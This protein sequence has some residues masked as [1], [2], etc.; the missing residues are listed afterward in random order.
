MINTLGFLF[1]CR[2][3]I[4]LCLLHNSQFIIARIR[5]LREGNVF[6]HVCQSFYSQGE[7]PCDHHPMMI[8]T[9]RIG[10]PLSH[11]AVQICSLGDS[12]PFLYLQTGSWS[13]PEMLTC[14]KMCSNRK[15]ANVDAL[16]QSRTHLIFKASI[17]ADA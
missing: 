10:I 14:F 5:S 11:G 12:P 17:N 6:S 4:Y 2:K 15:K 8:S 1:A 16:D 9:Y 13:T 3:N 7:C